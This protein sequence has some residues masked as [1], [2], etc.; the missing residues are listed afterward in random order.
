[1]WRGGGGWGRVSCRG[2]GLLPGWGLL[3]AVEGGQNGGGEGGEEVTQQGGERVGKGGGQH[4]NGNHASLSLKRDRSL[5]NSEDQN[6]TELT[7]K[8]R[9]QEREASLLRWQVTQAYIKEM[10]LL[11]DKYALERKFSD[12]RMLEHVTT[13]AFSVIDTSGPIAVCKSNEDVEDERYIFMTSLLGLLAEH[14]IWPSVTNASSI[15]VYV[16]N[17]Y[18]VLQ[19]KLQEKTKELNSIH[20]INGVNQYYEDSSQ[21]SS[22]N[23]QSP[24]TPMVILIILYLKIT[25]SVLSRSPHM[26]LLINAEATNPEYVVTADDI[27]KYIAVECIPMDE[28]G[29]QGEIVRLFANDQNKI[30]C[31]PEMPEEINSYISQGQAHFSVLVLFGSLEHWEAA[32]FI[33]HRSGFQVKNN[34]TEAVQIAEKFSKNL[35]KLRI[36]RYNARYYCANDKNV[37]KQGS[38]KGKRK[39][40][41]VSNSDRVL[42]QERSKAFSK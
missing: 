23:I 2:W 26:T 6:A 5:N 18:D 15:S 39:G 42:Q 19:W 24:Y 34:E 36:Y 12:L 38:R 41:T 7:A 37:P 32:T 40:S 11:N 13:C 25:I 33:L 4:G 3:S 29:R 10:Q 14:G 1:M 17:V 8:A 28:N 35:S 9:E 27:D 22:V 21:P 16:K 30:T 20:G 31:D